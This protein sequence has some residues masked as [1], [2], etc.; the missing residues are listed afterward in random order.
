MSEKVA[1]KPQ[2]LHPCLPARPEKAYEEDGCVSLLP[3][4]SVPQHCFNVTKDVH[5]ICLGKRFQVCYRK[6]Y[7]E[8]LHYTIR[9]WI[10]KKR[11]RKV[12]QRKDAAMRMWALNQNFSFS[13]RQP[14]N[15]FPNTLSAVIIL[16][17]GLPRRISNC[18]FGY[19]MMTFNC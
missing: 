15:F 10:P 17:K 14:E 12:K 11:V 6:G 19:Q 18:L 1:A 9:S 4:M 3:S 8:Q 2:C 16:V 13:N 5:G 7:N